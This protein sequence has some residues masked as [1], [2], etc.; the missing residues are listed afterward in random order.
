MEFNDQ[1]GWKNHAFLY[2][3]MAI[4]F[5]CCLFVYLRETIHLNLLKYRGLV[6]S[7]DSLIT[8]GKHYK[9]IQKWVILMIHPYPFLLGKIIK[10]EKSRKREK[11]E[12]FGIGYKFKML[13]TVTDHVIHYNINDIFQ[14]LSLLRLVFILNSLMVITQW[15]TSSAQ[16]IWYALFDSLT[17]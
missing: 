1:I 5:L 4:T 11:I 2:I 9:V 12:F 3:N 6:D 7:K 14:L 16:R 15:K 17:L 8:S 13:N 10:L